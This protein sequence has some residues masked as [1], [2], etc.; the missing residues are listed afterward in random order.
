MAADVLVAYL[1][2]QLSLR[3]HVMVTQM[4]TSAKPMDVTGTAN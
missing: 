4:N 2:T 1:V 3:Q